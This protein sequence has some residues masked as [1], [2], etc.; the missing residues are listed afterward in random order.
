MLGEK[1]GVMTNEEGVE[2]AHC[3]IHTSAFPVELWKA[4]VAEL[5]G[6]FSK[7]I[8]LTGCLRDQKCF[9]RRLRGLPRPG[10]GIM[11]PLGTVENGGGG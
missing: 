1:H 9:W 11:V 7:D 5:G 6:H 2:N 4:A 10:V 8:T 3:H